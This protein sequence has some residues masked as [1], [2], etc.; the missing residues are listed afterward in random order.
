MGS[1]NLRSQNLDGIS[2]NIYAPG[3]WVS[4]YSNVAQNNSNTFIFG[5]LGDANITNPQ[6]STDTQTG[7]HQLFTLKVEGSY[8]SY[9]VSSSYGDVTL[10]NV[11]NGRTIKFQL[12]QPEAGANNSGVDVQ[13]LDAGLAF[14]S[15]VDANS[16]AWSAYVTKGGTSNMWGTGSVALPAT[17]VQ[18]ALNLAQLGST[19]VNPADALATTFSSTVAVASTWSSTTGLGMINLD[20]ALAT[21]QTTVDP[22][23]LAIVPL[24]LQRLIGE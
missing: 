20:T 10:T 4:T 23:P 11:Q 15:Y 1:L 18:T 2:G 7:F 8:K 24:V 22:T 19:A 6:Y 16:G 5:T 12:S 9:I 13:F 3:D 21:G 17:G 14:T